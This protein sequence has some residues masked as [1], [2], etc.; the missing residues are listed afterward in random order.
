M[1]ARSYGSSAQPVWTP[2]QSRVLTTAPYTWSSVQATA[3]ARQQQQVPVADVDTP[4]KPEGSRPVRLPLTQKLLVCAGLIAL[5]LLASL[6]VSDCMLLLN[7]FNF[8]FWIGEGLPVT[9]I[10]SLLAAVFVYFITT[11]IVQDVDMWKRHNIATL[12][13]TFSIFLG[14]ILVLTSLYLYYRAEYTVSSLMYNCQG[15]AVTKDVRRN[16]LGLLALRMTPE[17]SQKGSIEECE[18]YSNVLAQ[19]AAPEDVAYL[20]A[21]EVDYHCSGFCTAQAN[22]SLIETSLSASSERF[23]R[24]FLAK[25]SSDLQLQRLAHNHRDIS[26]PPALFSKAA[27]KTSCDGSAARSLQFLAI[28][29]SQVWWWMS[30]V[31]IS[32]SA[33]VG[34]G[35]W[36][37]ASK[38]I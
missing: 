13:S 22:A 2:P 33:F 19:I 18:G 8:M 7:D 27:Y 35:E 25:G 28:G 24:I 12:V 23:P 36:L 21:L 37:S 14:A 20:K 1:F 11:S 16:Y 32:L 10:L 29:I 15:S 4:L 6:P 34:V 26:L 31:L 5:L 3:G 30:I 38:L 17:C 9:V